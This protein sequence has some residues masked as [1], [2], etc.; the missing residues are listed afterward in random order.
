MDR[1]HCSVDLSL[2]EV[3]HRVLR[4]IVARNCA[5]VRRRQHR[6]S[7]IRK[8]PCNIR[9]SGG[10]LRS[11]RPTV[12]ESAAISL[13][14]PTHNRAK[15][16]R[17]KER[18]LRRHESPTL[19]AQRYWNSAAGAAR[20]LQFRVSRRP[21]SLPRSCTSLSQS[22]ERGRSSDGSG[23]QNASAPRRQ[24]HRARVLERVRGLPRRAR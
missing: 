12:G 4:N 21:R 15:F 17:E 18:L 22:L 7:R 1:N 14:R 20:P 23:I 16:V 11:D 13:L 3:L 8:H 10:Q 19:S 5:L 24:P 2:V 9:P 6:P